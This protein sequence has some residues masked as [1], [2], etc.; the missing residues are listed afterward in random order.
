MLTFFGINNHLI[1][2]NWKLELGLT[3]NFEIKTKFRKNKKI[4]C[5]NYDFVP[6]PSRYHFHGIVTH[7]DTTVPH[8]P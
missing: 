6:L 5:R 8:R 2:S 3:I 7:G 1:I 4:Y